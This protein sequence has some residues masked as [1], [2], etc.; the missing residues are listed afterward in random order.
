MT[1]DRT[2]PEAGNTA[3]GTLNN[4]VKIDDERIKGHLDR[5]V[6]GTVEDT[7]NALLD[8][9]ADRLCNAQR[10]ERTEDRRDVFGGELGLE[11]VGIAP[12]LDTPDAPAR[13]EQVLD[14]RVAPFSTEQLPAAELVGRCRTDAGLGASG[15]ELV[16][17]GSAKGARKLCARQRV[18]VIVRS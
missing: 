9:E 4:I 10:Y 18:D 5:V 3:S 11:D 12:Q 14:C 16:R 8:A 1:E 13:I 2:I 6:R 15:C 17:L 7:L